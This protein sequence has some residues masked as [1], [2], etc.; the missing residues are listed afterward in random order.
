MQSFDE[1]AK[2]WDADPAKVERANTVAEL[3]RRRLALSPAMRA[4]EYG[5]GTGLLSFALR[6]DL[7][8]ITLADSSQG[9]LDV[10]REKIAKENVSD[11]T[12][13]RLDLLAD[14][15]PTERYDIVYSLMT[16]HHVP[17]LDT[18]FRAFHELLEAGGH[19]CVADLDRE[20]GSFHGPGFEGHQ[21]FDREDLRR[22]ARRA[23]FA[24]VRFETAL[25]ISKTVEGK[26]KSFP[27][28]LMIAEKGER[29]TA[30]G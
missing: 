17:D 29:S 20:D 5:C 16:L 23:G 30:R 1:R 19:L 21:G 2:A 26:R 22:R 11:M 7:G 10:L 12:P 18:I 6:A 25:E 15:L 13:V 9:M 3:M 24:E 8:P 4:L 28:F 27:V 14:P